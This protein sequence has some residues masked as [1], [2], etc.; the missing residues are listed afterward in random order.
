ME[1][2]S[3]PRGVRCTITSVRSDGKRLVGRFQARYDGASAPVAG[4][5]GMDGVTLRRAGDRAVDAT[6]TGHGTPVYGY[7]ATRS[8]DGR[9]LTVVSVHPVTRKPLRS[10]VVYDRLSP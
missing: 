6:F 3:I 5:A 1:C 7:R 4:I 9:T 2:V 10:V 8:E